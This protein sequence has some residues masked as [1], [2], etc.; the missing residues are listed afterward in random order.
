MNASRAAGSKTCPEEKGIKTQGM[1]GNFP[2]ALGSKTCPEEKGIKTQRCPLDKLA[3]S[4]FEDM[5]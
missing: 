1:R 3:V 2:R 4:L 5:P